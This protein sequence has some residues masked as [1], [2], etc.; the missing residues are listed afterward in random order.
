M[1]HP[2]MMDAFKGVY[3]IQL[4]ADTWG[5]KEMQMRTGLRF[6]VIPMLFAVDR[7]G[8]PVARID[9]SA[10][11]ADTPE[12]MAAALKAF[13]AQPATKARAGTPAN[14]SSLPGDWLP[15]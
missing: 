10:W 9:G 11:G 15:A 3:L 8:R 14:V 6:D 7:E 13:F 1:Q 2:M 4:D 5:M 12:N